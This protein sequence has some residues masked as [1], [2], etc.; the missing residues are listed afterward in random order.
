LQDKT[1][2]LPP[3]I[4]E[5]IVFGVDYSTSTIARIFGNIFPKKAVLTWNNVTKEIS[6]KT[7][8]KTVFSTSYSSI[9]SFH[10]DFSMITITCNGKRYTCFPDDSVLSVLSNVG[11][12]TTNQSATIALGTAKVESSGIPELAAYIKNEGVNVTYAKIGRSVE[13]GIVSGFIILFTGGIIVS[14]FLVR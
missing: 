11:V 4:D 5:D 1:P 14:V 8:D 2:T 7:K 13:L 3:A 9:E 10:V 12:A 6:L